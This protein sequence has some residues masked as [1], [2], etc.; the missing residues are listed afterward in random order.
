M[1]ARTVQSNSKETSGSIIASTSIVPART[2]ERKGK[3]NPRRK[4]RNSFPVL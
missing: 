4:L 3:D 2:A 1:Q